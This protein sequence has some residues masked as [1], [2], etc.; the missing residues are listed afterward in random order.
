MATVKD[1]KEKAKKDQENFIDTETLPK[2]DTGIPL[3]ESELSM[4]KKLDESRLRVK[5]EFYVLA[6]SEVNLEERRKKNKQAHLENIEFEKQLGEML[7]NK[8]G[9]GIVDPTNGVFI[10]K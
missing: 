6:I 1:V 4:I 2:M 8:Y 7:S 5:E 9:D 10:P 3:T